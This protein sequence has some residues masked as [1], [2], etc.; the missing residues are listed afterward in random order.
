M[1][2]LEELLKD[3]DL[4]AVLGSD[5]LRLLLLKVLGMEYVHRLY[6]RVLGLILMFPIHLVAVAEVLYKRDVPT[7]YVYVTIGLCLVGVGFFFPKTT[8]PIFEAVK[9]RF[10][11]ATK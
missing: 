4:M 7:Y 6:Q 9:T 11:N 10:I 8:E 1:E 5:N 2:K 3:K